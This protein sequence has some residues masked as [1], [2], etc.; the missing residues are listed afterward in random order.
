MTRA[1]PTLCEC[2]TRLDAKGCPSC[3]AIEATKARVRAQV[4]R[5]RREGM[6]ERSFIGLAPR[7]VRAGAAKV[8]PV[9]ARRQAEQSKR[10]MRGKGKARVLRSE[11][12][13]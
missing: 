13:R 8:D 9:E 1:T 5:R 4:E 11:P 7:A 3:R 6:E 12:S 2:G 10:V